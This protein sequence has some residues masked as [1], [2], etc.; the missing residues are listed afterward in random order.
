MNYYSDAAQDMFQIFANSTNFIKLVKFTDS[1][2]FLHGVIASVL[3][4]EIMFANNLQGNGHIWYLKN[5]G[6]D[7]L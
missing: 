5:E 3:I 7:R 6:H 1:D 4:F 2:Q